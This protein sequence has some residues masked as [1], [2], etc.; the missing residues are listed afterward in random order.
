[1][2]L[3]VATGAY[4]GSRSIDRLPAE[5]AEPVVIALIAAITLFVVFNPGFGT[6]QSISDKSAASSKPLSLYRQVLLSLLAALAIGFHDGFFG[7]GTGV[8]FV[9]VLISIWPLD[10]LLAT[11][12]AKV[13]NFVAN[14]VALATF[15]ISGNIQYDKG[16]CG[17]AGVIIGSFLGATFATRKGT[18]LIK[19]LFIAVTTVLVGKLLFEYAVGN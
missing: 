19:P 2:G 14:V 8:F 5:W 7:P 17:A 12:S 13:L 4:W 1:M 16:I 10:F 3:P 6:A 18:K 9:F 15:A 11:G